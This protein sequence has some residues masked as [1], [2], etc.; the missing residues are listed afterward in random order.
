MA[1]RVLTYN[2]VSDRETIK[3]GQKLGAVLKEGD[4]I[5]LVGELGSGKT[6]FAKGIAIG[7]GIS[8]GTVITS[9][10]FSLLNEYEGR[11]TFFHMDAYR[12]ESLSDFISAGLDEYFFQDGVV[13]MEWADRW[14]EI[15]PDWR[16]K[17]EF[18]IVDKYLRKIALSGYH[19]RAVEI[20]NGV[21]QQLD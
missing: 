11:C 21:Q 1:E 5:A 13:A 3:L 20:L 15:L 6:W 8:P 18:A 4:V 7:L 9:P 2:T 17:V 16:V 12:L 19:A 10:S 14:L